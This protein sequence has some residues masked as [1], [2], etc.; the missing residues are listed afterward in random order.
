[1]STTTIRLDE[2]L[3]VRVAHAAEI[4]GKSPHAFI[5]E[6]VVRLLEQAEAEEELHQVAQKRWANLLETG[7]SVAWS[8]LKEYV[9]ARAAG[10]EAARPRARN[11]G[12]QRAETRKSSRAAD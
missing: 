11:P 10:R 1:M 6:A 5:V 4:T 7:K 12:A 8:D 2:D 9:G 3:R